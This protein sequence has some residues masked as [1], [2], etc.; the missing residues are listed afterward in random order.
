VA[1]SVYPAVSVLGNG[2]VNMSPRQWLGKLVPAAVPAVGG[3]MTDVQR[4]GG[5]DVYTHGILPE[6][7]GSLCPSDNETDMR[8]G[9][10]TSIV[11]R[12]QED[13]ISV[14]K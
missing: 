10:V 6:W 9:G 2:S 13:E 11:R 4:S 1:L 3:T 12:E 14:E 8:G 7:P 5:R